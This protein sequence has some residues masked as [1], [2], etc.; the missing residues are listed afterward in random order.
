MEITE[1]RLL[2]FGTI[3]LCL[4]LA[5]LYALNYKEE[6]CDETLVNKKSIFPTHKWELI[7]YKESYYTDSVLGRVWFQYCKKYKCKKCGK[8]Y[9]D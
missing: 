9:E 3:L 7:S 6:K 2:F 1:I 4:C 5:L 8:T